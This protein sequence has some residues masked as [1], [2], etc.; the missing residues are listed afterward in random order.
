MPSN[1]PVMYELECQRGRISPR[2]F[3]WYCNQRLKAKAGISLDSWVDYDYWIDETHH[4]ND[5]FNHPDWDPPAVE[6]I[7]EYPYDIQ[8]FLSGA[9]NFM[10]EYQFGSG[11]NDGWGYMYV[12]EYVR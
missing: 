5:K 8:L 10:L 2:E 12:I 7:K 9:Y 4:T 11:N 6:V 3:Y 1:K